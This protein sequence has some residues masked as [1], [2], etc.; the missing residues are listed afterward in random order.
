MLMIIAM[1]CLASMFLSGLVSS[2]PSSTLGL[3]QLK[4]S[5]SGFSSPT[6]STAA[7]SASKQAAANVS[8]LKQDSGTNLSEM[9]LTFSVSPTYGSAQT[10][11]FTAPKT[12]WKLEG[13][14]VMAT[15]GWNASAKDLPKPLPFTIEIRDASLRLLYH[16]SDTQL[17]YFT[18]GQGIRLAY[19]EM[20]EMPITGDFFVCFYGYRSIGLA[21]ELQNATG[22]SYV[23][24]KLTGR[25]YSGNL[26]LKNNKTL[27]INYI[28]RVLGQ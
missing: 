4:Q 3:N 2:Q 24:D 11:K 20:P 25:L 13:V 18:N 14:S 12:G 9:N 26:P 7:N 10:V 15:D 8:L 22:N 6:A 1:L 28:I 27:P 16:Y 17:P 5:G 19:V 23:F 21:T